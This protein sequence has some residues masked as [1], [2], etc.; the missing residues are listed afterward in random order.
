MQSYSKHHHISTV[1]PKNKRCVLYQNHQKGIKSMLMF[2]IWPTVSIRFNIREP[3]HYYV[4][5]LP[6]H[7]AS[8]SLLLHGDRLL[9][10]NSIWLGYPFL[11][12]RV[13]KV[14]SSANVTWG[15]EAS[16]CFLSSAASHKLPHWRI[17]ESQWQWA[18]E[19]GRGIGRKKKIG[20]RA[21]SAMQ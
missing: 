2:P 20:E 12:Y 17:A 21:A 7:T 6:L 9:F 19:K 15:P 1:E 18:E 5:Y 16:C 3:L 14:Q 10:L 8:I 13:E 11:P 4:H